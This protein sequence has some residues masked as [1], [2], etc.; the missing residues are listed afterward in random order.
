[1]RENKGDP[2]EMPRYSQ[3]SGQA[4]G[5]VAEPLATLPRLK[6]KAV[7]FPLWVISGHSH[8]Q[9]FRP[10]SAT[11]RHLSGAGRG[12]EPMLAS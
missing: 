7:G 1:M 12:Q 9:R 8:R 5:I 6:F 10:L 4:T 11:S 3:I 2:V